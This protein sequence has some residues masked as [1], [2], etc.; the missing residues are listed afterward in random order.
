MRVHNLHE[1]ESALTAAQP[2]VNWPS[3]HSAK[4]SYSE[5]TAYKPYPVTKNH[6][7]PLDNLQGNDFPADAKSVI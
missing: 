1:K 2:F 3:R 4:K 7:Q 6:F 5:V